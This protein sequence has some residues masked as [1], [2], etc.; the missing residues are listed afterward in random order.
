MT[1]SIIPTEILNRRNTETV[2]QKLIEQD[3]MLR[4]QEIRINTL[5]Q[6]ISAMS[7]RMNALENMVLIQKVKMASSGPSVIV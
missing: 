4:E 5:Q 7:E 1:K 6:T 2:Q 3:I